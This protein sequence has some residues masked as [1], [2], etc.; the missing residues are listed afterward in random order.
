MA[1]RESF[2]LAREAGWIEAAL[3]RVWRAGWRTDDLVEDG[4]R[5]VGTR[6]MGRLTAE[7]VTAV[8]EGA[9]TG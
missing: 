1:L 5:R 4:C 8:R 6:E 7:A 2:G 9:P 3:R